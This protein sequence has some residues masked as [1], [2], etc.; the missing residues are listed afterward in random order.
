VTIGNNSIQSDLVQVG[1]LQAQH[2]IDTLAVN[3]YGLSVIK[4]PTKLLH[5]LSKGT[6]NIGRLADLIESA[7]CSTEPRLD[8]LLAVLVQ[9]VEHLQVGARR[10]LDELGESVSHLGDRQR[11]QKGKV[12]KGVHGGVVCAQAVLVSAI[13]DGHLDADAGVNETNNGSGNAD[14]VGVASVGGAS[15]TLSK[16]EL[17]VSRFVNV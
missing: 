7:I 13:V 8:Q 1:R 15:K 9:Q 5:E 6:Y 12:Q 3:L 2:L 16:K 17:W 11:A 4:Q 14:K 10:D